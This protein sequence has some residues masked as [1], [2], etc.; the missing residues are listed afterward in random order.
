MLVICTMVKL[1][2]IVGDN[3]G[4]SYDAI[5]GQLFFQFFSF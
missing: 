4:F 3:N 2:F 5:K 1:N